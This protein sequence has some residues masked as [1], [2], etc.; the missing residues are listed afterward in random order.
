MAAILWSDVTDTAADLAVVSANAQTAILAFVN[1]ALDTRLFANGESD[2][3]LKLA[4]VYLA[5][6]YGA[7]DAGG[8]GG[9]GGPLASESGGGLARTYAV[10]TTSTTDP[11]LELTPWGKAYRLIMRPMRGGCVL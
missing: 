7:I 1:E 9:P 10:L 2:N 11:L 6:H 5:A 3:R 8:S 4:R